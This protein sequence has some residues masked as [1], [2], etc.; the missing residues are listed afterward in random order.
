MKIVTW[1]INSVRIRLDNIKKLRDELNPDIIALQEIKVEDSKF[2]I[3]EIQDL[4]YEYCYFVGQKSYN[5]VAILSKIKPKNSFS[6]Q[7]VNQDARHIAIVLDNDIEIHNFYVHSGGDIPDTN[8][9]KKFADK[10]AYIDQ[11][12]EW[13]ISNRKADDKLV[14]VGDLNISPYEH[15]VWSSHQLRNEISH[16]MIEREKL[17]R[18]LNSINFLDIAREQVPYSEKLY[19]WWSYRNRDWQKSNRGRRLD[20]IWAT[21]PLSNIKRFHILKEARSWDNPS[22]HVPVFCEF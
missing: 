7:L 8:I 22:D 4:G 17:M 13:F 9:N 3:K 5:G 19:S 20:H 18:L 1:N 11:M 6:I 15:D 14:I 10:L 12:E 16:T 21:K 2:P